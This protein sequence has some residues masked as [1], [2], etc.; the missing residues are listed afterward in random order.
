MICSMLQADSIKNTITALYNVDYLK[1]DFSKHF[2]NIAENIFKVISSEK[3]RKTRMTEESADNVISCLKK[4]VENHSAIKLVIPFG[5]YKQA[6]LS[7]SPMPDWAE[8]FNISFMIKLALDIENIYHDKVEVIYLNQNAIVNL[9]DSYPE[10]LL[11]QY[12][13]QFEKILDFFRKKLRNKNISIRQELMSELPNISLVIKA[14]QKT[15]L[16]EVKVFELLPPESKNQKIAMAMRNIY[17]NNL[18]IAEE[19]KEEYAK[20]T[21]VLHQSFLKVDQRIQKEYFADKIIITLRKGA[22]CGIH[23]GSCSSSTVQFW[24]G[25]GFLNRI[26]DKLVPVILSYSQ[27]KSVKPIETKLEIKELCDLGLDKISIVDNFIK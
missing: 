25:E 4:V 10:T 7:C 6:R 8:F 14:T 9:I 22:R 15:Y 5:G 1:H 26:K 3:Y 24:A 27:Q 2:D 17:W 21:C 18:N 16:S 11:K 12:S 13:D 20:K 19:R 23:C